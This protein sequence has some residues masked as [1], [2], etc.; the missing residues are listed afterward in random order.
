VRSSV[1]D[2]PLLEFGG[3][4]RHVDPRHGISDYGPVDLHE[5]GAPRPIRLGIVG[6]RSDIDGLRRWL[7]ECSAGVDARG[8]THLRS[9]FRDFPGLDDDRTFRTTLLT[10]HGTTRAVSAT[11]LRKATSMTPGLATERCV[12]L[13]LEQIQDLNQ[14]NRVDAILVARPD[15]LH[16][17]K[18]QPT[19]DPDEH[20]VVDP[21]QADFHDLL[22]S[23]CLDGVPAQLIRSSTWDPDRKHL[24]D[25]S[26]S[27]Q[28]HATRVWNLF[29][30]LYYKAGGKPWRLERSDHDLR[31]LFVG[32]SFFRSADENEVHTA[33]AQVFDERGAG[34]VV[35]G[36][37][38]A[39]RKSDRQPH[40]NRS[41]A[42]ALLLDAVRTFRREHQHTPARVVI[43]KTSQ[44]DDPEIAGFDE[45]ASE[46]DLEELDLTWLTDQS[47]DVR[48]FRNGTN[49]V[50][51]GTV[52]SLD[53]EQH[54][55]YTRGSVGFYRVYPGMYVPRPIG[56][57][58]ARNGSDPMALAREVLA[59]SKLNWNQSQ[60][61]T[62]LPVTIGAAR[63]VS[64]IL[65]HV[66]GRS[67]TVARY[68]HFM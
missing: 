23:R 22:K 40:L 61:D 16:D 25:T 14:T 33:V 62:R 66:D 60:L 19:N 51:R 4:A 54:L 15:D 35:R 30:A 39:R 17:E 56:L 2:E 28:D 20:V 31:T 5:A 21:F 29:T 38:A 63:K 52:L 65:K 64:N 18:T 10:T 53:R 6:P 45:A 11:E 47:E 46:L 59:L 1:L 3:G 26:R 34:V 12:D 36:G 37:P 27:Q 9:L 8:D 58:L 24:R 55:V 67:T 32:V 48:L 13:Y 49:P 7:G 41:D 43:H 57:R 44:H 50:L 68:A 42:K